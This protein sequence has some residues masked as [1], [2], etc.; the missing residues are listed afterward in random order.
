MPPTVAQNE[1]RE[2]A[3]IRWLTQILAALVYESG[4][5]GNHG[6]LVV[7]RTSLTADHDGFD[8][9][10]SKDIKGN[11]ILRF[12][13]VRNLAVYPLNGGARWDGQKEASKQ[14]PISE[15]SS[16]PPPNLPQAELFPDLPL[17]ANLNGVSAPKSQA[18]IRELE[19]V[20]AK[21]KM[22][23]RIVAG[24]LKQ[25]QQKRASL[26]G[27]LENAELFNSGR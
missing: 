17:Q 7:K 22:V 25:E 12:E 10:E 9:M 16:V 1:S 5:E 24:R 19:R 27:L 11:I 20:L 21:Q 18:Q 3:T 26:E 6:C 2:Q 15:P 8:L 13:S 14:E 4:G 23:N